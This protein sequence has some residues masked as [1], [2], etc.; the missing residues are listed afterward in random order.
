MICINTCKGYTGQ[1]DISLI[2]LSVSK[3]YEI[4]SDVYCL[5]TTCFVYVMTSILV[6]KLIWR[7]S[8]VEFR[9]SFIPDMTQLK[10]LNKKEDLHDQSA[11]TVVK[12]M[13]K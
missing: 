8:T 12:N 10:V 11:H 2:N 7:V 3:D 6:M 9:F 13:C 1:R 4:H 5:S